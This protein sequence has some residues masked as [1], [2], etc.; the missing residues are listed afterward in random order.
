MDVT[1]AEFS[2]A[3]SLIAQL[4]GALGGMRILRGTINSDGSTAWGSGFSSAKNATGD[5]TVTLDEAFGD[6]PTV[7]LS[8]NQTAGA[9]D[10]KIKGGVAVTTSGFSVYTLTTTSGALTDS[11]WDF[12]AIGPA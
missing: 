11:A 6:E 1:R 3:M 7:V 5:Y 8:C 2:R 4:Q 12:I 9:L 10:A